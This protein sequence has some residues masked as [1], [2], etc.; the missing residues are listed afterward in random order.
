MTWC[1]CRTPQVFNAKDLTS[2]FRHFM[3]RHQGAAAASGGGGDE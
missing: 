2:I 1:H 3:S